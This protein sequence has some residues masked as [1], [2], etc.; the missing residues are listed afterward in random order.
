MTAERPGTHGITPRR[1]RKGKGQPLSATV[2]LLGV[3]L[4]IALGA[5]PS[6]SWQLPFTQALL[7]MLLPVI[8]VTIP[9]VLARPLYGFFLLLLLLPVEGVF[10]RAFDAEIKFYYLVAGS[11]AIVVLLVG[12]ARGRIAYVRNALTIPVLFFYVINLVS[13]LYSP[14]KVD[15]LQYLV[16]FAFLLAIYFL[17]SF[18]VGTRRVYEQSLA[19][20]LFV[21]MV[22][23]GLGIL[24][25]ALYRLMGLKLLVLLPS[26][27]TMLAN[28]SR[29]SSLFH[30]P[31]DLGAFLA[32]LVVLQVS[33]LTVGLPKHTRLLMGGLPIAALAVV[34]SESRAALVGIACGLGVLFCVLMM[35]GKTAVLRRLV[36]ALGVA[37][38][39]V[40]TV[41]VV[42][43]GVF[44]MFSYRATRLL[45]TQSINPTTG[46]V[47]P[48]STSPRILTMQH[49]LS[50]AT[51]S[52]NRALLGVGFGTWEQ[53]ARQLREEGGAQNNVLL[54]KGGASLPVTAYYDSGVAG[55]FS[56]LLIAVVYVGSHLRALALATDQF[57]RACL[58]ASLCS[59]VGLLVSFAF[60]NYFFLGFVW[61]QLGLGGAA[62]SLAVK[63]RANVR[64]EA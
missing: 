35:E 20:I 24:Q 21:G 42:S 12:L 22:V 32:Y 6:L 52:D 46:L 45:A 56:V 15:T 33:L 63:N 48:R 53:H 2:V 4:G 1:R 49:M 51:A 10:V 38:V 40:F 59:F 61:A 9:I 41:A 25:L 57:W 28:T 14:F 16:L 54:S 37:V 19:V 11:L 23:S 13:I 50:Q 8:A 58:V 5:M 18:F 26:Q 47:N 39:V 64:D 36:Q 30:E 27:E 31:D 60:S 62:V 3:C 34:L 44:E 17:V 55:L 29:I 7:L 43:P